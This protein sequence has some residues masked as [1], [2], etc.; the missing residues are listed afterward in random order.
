VG[1][2]T[3]VKVGKTKMIVEVAVGMGVSVFRV[4]VI[5]GL[6]VRV[7]IAAA[8]WEAAAS[9]VC[10]I[11]VLIAPGSNEG[12]EGVTRDGREGAQARIRARAVNQT[13]NFDLR[14]AVIIASS[15]SD[16]NANSKVLFFNNDG[17]IRVA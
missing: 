17:Y 1:R 14:D 16:Q 11:N 6:G 4:G 13:N 2:I 9:T 5:V 8:V 7:G 12:T 15:T 3:A 10:A